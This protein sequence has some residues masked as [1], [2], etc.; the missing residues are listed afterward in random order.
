MMT[1]PNGKFFCVTGPL[2]ENSPVTGEFP[3]QRPVKRSIDV[4]FDLC[5]NKRLM[6]QSRGWWFQTPSCSLWC[7]YNAYCE[8]LHVNNTHHVVY[9][10]LH[11]HLSSV[12]DVTSF[13][14]GRRIKWVIVSN[15]IRWVF[16]IAGRYITSL[17]VSPSLPPNTPGLFPFVWIPAVVFGIP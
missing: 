15:T 9:R 11:I 17:F 6:K 1:S 12:T 3:S 5:L 7:Y 13:L 2:C 10:F 4:F 8:N 16:V 14:W